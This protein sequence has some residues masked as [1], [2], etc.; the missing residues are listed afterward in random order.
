MR[1]AAELSPY[2]DDDLPDFWHLRPERV[3]EYTRA[4]ATAWLRT[5]S[6]ERLTGPWLGCDS[7]WM[8]GAPS[9][10]SP[11]PG[12]SRS[13]RRPSSWACSAGSRSAG[14]WRAG[15]WCSPP[16]AFSLARLRWIVVACARVD[17]LPPCARRLDLAMAAWIAV[18]VA[19]TGA[20]A[21]F[22]V[23][24]TW[25]SMTYHLA[26]VAHWA[27]DHTVAFYPTHVVR[28]LYPPPWAEYA[29]LHLS[30]W[31]ERSARESR[32]V[33][34][35]GCEPRR[36]QRDRAAARGRPARPA[37]ERVRV[38]DH[39]DGHHAGVDH[40][41]RLRGR[42]LARVSGERAPRASRRDPGLFRC[43]A[44]ERASAWRS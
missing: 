2:S 15:W 24:I 5:C 28:Q 32:P 6:P 21:L 38:R 14:Y 27:Q 23:P 8:S 40:A 18:V 30:S 33:G 16:P 22:A 43:S 11:F 12:A 9:W 7:S 20:I 34:Q 1:G 36:R 31:P 37:P 29:M 44:P 4:V 42:A 41:E 17:R 25:D 13:P 35:H 10:W 26:R 39:P 3:A 19:L